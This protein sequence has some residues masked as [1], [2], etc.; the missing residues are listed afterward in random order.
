[1]AA[2]FYN[3]HHSPI[4]AFASLTLG[5]KGATGG[6]G[7]E[8][9]QPA[10]QPVYMGLQ[11][12][13]G[14]YIDMLPFYG[15]VGQADPAARFQVEQAPG[16]GIKEESKG[17]S[18]LKLRPFADTD[19][20]RNMA[21]S[22]DEWH[23][24][25]LVVRVISPVMPV[26]DPAEAELESLKVAIV[27]AI[28]VEF[29]VDNR[30]CALER[31]A[32]FGY[33]G[34]DPYSAMR[35]LDDTMPGYAGVGQGTHTAVVAEQGSA[36]SALGFSIDDILAIHLPENCQFGLGATGL[37]T[38][39]AAADCI[40]RF[41]FAVC[42]YRD[43][44]ATA[45]LASSYLYTRYFTCIEQVAQFAL[46]HYEKLR[47]LA[48]DADSR[49][50]SPH[51]TP[52]QRWMVAHAIRSYYGC[53]QL[54]TTNDDPLWV[55]NEG[56]YRMMNTFDLTVDQLFYEMMSNPWT[57]KNVL[58]QFVDRYSYEDEVTEP[59][60]SHR[61]PGG[62]S[63]T[64]DMGVG[65][66]FSRPEYSS[67]E[68]FGLRG[69]FSHMT[70]EQLVNWILCAA[71]YV[72]GTN[73]ESWCASKLTTLAAC[74][75][76]MVNRD[77]YLEEK[78]DGVMSLESTRT[79]GGAEITTYDSLDESLGQARA[80]VYLA[81]KCWAAYIALQ[82]IFTDHGLE[83]LAELAHRQAVLCATT[84]TA[85]AGE[86]GQIPAL[87]EGNHPSRI[88]PAIEGLVFPLHTGCED[89]VR[90]SG[91]YADLVNALGRH[92]RSVLVPNVCLFDDGGW[93]L[94]STARNSWLSKIYLCQH[95]ARK[96]LGIDGPAVTAN[97]D[98]AHVG[99]LTDEKNGY[100]AWSDQ[101]VAGVAMA[102]RYYPRGVTSC[103]WLNE[104]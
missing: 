27:P 38:V 89:A 11:S 55:V 59:G 30:G 37:L 35:R 22:I 39:T 84:V 103:L 83:D 34:T 7:L 85:S 40:S 101:M 5:C 96:V 29:E 77:H 71:V 63:F 32:V 36:V 48:L 50:A 12:K 64:H 4:G 3:A 66:V 26:P 91:E 15:S 42:F 18:A 70:H 75:Q 104:E 102:S 98:R 28:L 62:I 74:L 61:Y 72:H 56:E 25:D 60:A 93:K 67:Y 78:R 80:N 24:G 88:I 6:L 14:Q 82:R 45:G 2:I 20:S 95:V 49:F 21:A 46:Q 73:D 17:S 41:R 31:K 99:W 19:I 54:L 13:D 90:P 10:N 52:D 53:S 58:D 87:L 9:A 44:C 97:A 92:F 69:C 94:S 65:N 8:L 33:V 76:S 57:V 1:M 51:L 43:G 81:V 100:W 47:Q 16:E 68:K 23:A 86:D 79:S